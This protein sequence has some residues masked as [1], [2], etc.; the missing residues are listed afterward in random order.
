MPV[1]H[2]VVDVGETAPDFELKDQHGQQVRLSSFRGRQ[3]VLLVFYPFSFTGVCAGELHALEAE[4]PEL[5]SSGVA[6]L[7]VSVDSMFT[8]R[9]YA[10][11]EEFSFPLLADFWPH[12]RVASSYGVFSESA[13]AALRGSF[14]IDTDGIVRW[15][16]VNEIPDARDLDEVRKAVAAL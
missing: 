4:W 5:R 11:R 7:A 15:T 8:Q 10:E 2:K 12:G 6:L 1:E 14:L 9:V 13:G 3:P 16:V